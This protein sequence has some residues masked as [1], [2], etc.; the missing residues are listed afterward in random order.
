LTLISEHYDGRTYWSWLRFCS[1]TLSGWATESPGEAPKSRCSRMS[2]LGEN[3]GRSARRAVL[4]SHLGLRAPNL[5]LLLL[6]GA[7]NITVWCPRLDTFLAL[8]GPASLAVSIQCGDLA[9]ELVHAAAQEIVCWPPKKKWRFLI[10]KSNRAPLLRLA[11]WRESCKGRELRDDNRF[12]IGKWLFNSC[13]Y[14]ALNIGDRSKFINCLTGTPAHQ[15][16][17]PRGGNNLFKRL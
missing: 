1:L 13:P 4:Q 9:T 14:R 6:A 15:L 5:L 2:M 10:T 11:E 3:G 7:G 8:N 16:S 12:P 17:T